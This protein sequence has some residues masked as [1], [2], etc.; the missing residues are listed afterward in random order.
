MKCP[1]CDIEMTRS[2]IKHDFEDLDGNTLYV[3]VN[4]EWCVE[5]SYYTLY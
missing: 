1:N 5:C 2:R 3:T 4:I